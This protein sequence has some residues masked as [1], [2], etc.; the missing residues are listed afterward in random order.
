MLEAI[1][2]MKGGTERELYYNTEINANF[3][4]TF[5][6][7]GRRVKEILTLINTVTT[8][9]NGSGCNGQ[10]LDIYDCKFLEILMHQEGFCS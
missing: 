8:R 1:P 2:L 7:C 6:S 4:K 5:R 3:F 10:N 9:Y